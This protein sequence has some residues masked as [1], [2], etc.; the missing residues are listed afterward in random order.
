MKLCPTCNLAIEAEWWS[1]C[2]TCGHHL[3]A[4]SAVAKASMWHS[5]QRPKR[6]GWAPGKYLCNCVLCGDRFAG[7]KR[8]I[9]CA[10][11]AYDKMDTENHDP[12]NQGPDP[13]PQGSSTDP[14]SPG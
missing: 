1:Y 6:N 12:A 14:A 8:A 4:E 10:P 5:D 3:A 9:H 13:A 11:C 7:D 2:P